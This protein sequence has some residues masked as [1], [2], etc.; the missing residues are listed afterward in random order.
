[1]EPLKQ[2]GNGVGLEVENRVENGEGDKVAVKVG[3][4]IKSVL[5]ISFTSDDKCAF[6]VEESPQLNSSF[7]K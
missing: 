1:M 5:I 6:S 2:E 4:F 3:D 7:S